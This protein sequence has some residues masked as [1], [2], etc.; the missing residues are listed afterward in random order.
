MTLPERL[1][2]PPEAHILLAAGD[3]TPGDG[4]RM[5]VWAFDVLKYVAPHLHLI[6]V[7]DGPERERV[8][9]FA[10]S[11]GAD[12]LRVHSLI[13]DNPLSVIESADVIWGTHPKG[14]VGFLRAATACG[15]PALALRTA[16]TE[17]IDGV[18]LTPCGDAVA[19][20]TATRKVLGELV[21]R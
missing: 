20:A 9:R 5:A 13:G 12:D 11:L 6:L 19:L 18:I 21:A 1:G 2:L 3:F 10:W 17:G 16:D 4:M 14:G 15:K 7:G 8:L